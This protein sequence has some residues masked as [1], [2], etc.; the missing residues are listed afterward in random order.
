MDKGFKG[1]GLDRRAFFGGLV[2]AGSSAMGA[3]AQQFDP[4]TGNMVYGGA[5]QGQAPDIGAWQVNPNAD[6]RRNLSAFRMWHWSDHFSDLGVGVILADV[7]S[8]ALHYWSAGEATYRVYPCSVPV[9]EELTKRGKT[10]VVRKAKNPPWTPTPDMRKKDPSLPLRVEGGVP[11]NPLGAYGLYL[12]WP[13]Y[14]IHGTHD[15]RKIGRLS[16]NGCYGLY[17]EHV[18]ELYDLAEIGT[19]VAVF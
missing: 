11:E 4:S 7:S 2:C 14:L 3:F 19:Q 1:S 6:R 13:A 18:T 8:R 17:N 16:S 15:T 9:T 12:S 10:E 5:G